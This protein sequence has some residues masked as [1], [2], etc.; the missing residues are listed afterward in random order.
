MIRRF[1]WFFLGVVAGMALYNS[2]RNKMATLAQQITLANV[3]SH[4]W[5]WTREAATVL[6]GV[7]SGFISSDQKSDRSDAQQG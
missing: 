1:F 6:I 4:L 3:A 2:I 5:E 7:V